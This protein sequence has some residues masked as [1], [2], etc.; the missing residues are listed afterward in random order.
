[1]LSDLHLPGF[2]QHQAAI[3]N[4]IHDAP[5]APHRRAKVLVHNVPRRP[6]VGRTDDL[7]LDAVALLLAG[8]EGRQGRLFAAGWPPFQPCLPARNRLMGAGLL[9]FRRRPRPLL[10]VVAR[11]LLRRC[12]RLSRRSTPRRPVARSC[13]RLSAW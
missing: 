10:G 1:V 12:R 5:V 4:A 13:W 2:V 9:A 6:V 7:R 8:P 3:G 11:P